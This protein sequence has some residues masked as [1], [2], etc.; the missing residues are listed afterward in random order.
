MQTLYKVSLV[1]TWQE[2]VTQ[3][4]TSFRSSVYIVKIYYWV[5]PPFPHSRNLTHFPPNGI[6][7]YEACIEKDGKEQLKT[8]IEVL[9]FQS[10]YLSVGFQVTFIFLIVF[11]FFIFL[12]FLKCSPMNL[13]YSF[14]Q[15]KTHSNGWFKKPQA[16]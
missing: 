12:A 13:Y 8:L 2:M 11:L 9:S 1:S 5:F 10:S 16:A 7:I 6:H 4:L 15:R 14:N 3:T